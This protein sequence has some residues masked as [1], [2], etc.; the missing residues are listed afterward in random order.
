L[1]YH[2]WGAFYNEWIFRLTGRLPGLVVG[3]DHWLFLRSNVT[4]LGARERDGRV[5]ENLDFIREVEERMAARGIMLFVVLTPDRSRVYPERVY[6]D[7]P[8]PPQRAAFLPQIE[9]QLESAGIE[10]VCLTSTFRKEVLEGRDTY[11]SEDHHWNHHGSEMAAKEVAGRLKRKCD[12]VGVPG[13][14]SFSVSEEMV[15]GSPR[16]S[17]VTLLKF[18][19]ESP[20]E[21]RFLRVQRVVEFTPSWEALDQG[22]GTAAGIVFESS[23]G[24]YGFPQY[25]E[26]NLDAKVDSIVEPGNGSVFAI[27]RFLVETASDEESYRFAVWE[28]P[29]YHLVEGLVNQGLGSPIVLPDPFP[30]SDAQRLAPAKGI[31]V[32]GMIAKGRR[33]ETRVP[34]TSMEITFDEP[35]DRIRVRCKIQG[36]EKRGQ[37]LCRSSVDSGQ[38]LLTKTEQ[39]VT[40]DF[41]LDE[42]TDRVALSLVFPESGYRIL[43]LEVEGALSKP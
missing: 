28:I 23:F 33:Y 14:R 24:K 16:R 37:I 18:R 25:L 2:S 29:E 36:N 34:D 5:G 26:M 11:F 13:P 12:L 42:A 40:Y 22:D 32:S 41:R 3:K 7:G 21:S 31:E 20:V 8:V 10:V 6:G 9:E 39:P 38:L 30:A 15:A 27:S 1:V 4:E 43:N 17:L 19:K 35:V